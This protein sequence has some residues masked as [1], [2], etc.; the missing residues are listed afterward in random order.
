M[1]SLSKFLKEK[2]WT[3]VAVLLLLLLLLVIGGVPGYL[4]GRWQWKQPPPV[5][6][7][8]ELK[9]IRKAGLTLSGW[10]TVEQTEQSI[11]EH[12]WSL[13]I[14]KKADSQTQ[15]ILLLLPQNGP[16]D[17]PEVEW[18]EVNGWGK[19]R[20]GQWDIAQYRSAKLTIKYPAAGSNIETR[21]KARFFR[22]S[23][24]QETFA[25]LQ[26]YALPDGGDT[27]PI[28]WFLADQIAQW[29]KR[30]TPW[31]AVSILIPIE[32]LGQVET[33]WPLAQSLGETVQA[34]LMAGPLANTSQV[35]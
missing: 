29:H 7:L 16:M 18:T 4:T 31:V 13:Q 26:W 24:Q 28:H 30:R 15:A 1:I 21:V 5:V 27:S 32:P 3:Y 9:Q 23:T 10:Q 19:S 25:A 20:W 22:V 33:A 35:R 11:G 12:K 6:N 2:Q 14:L 17:Q 34:T 8:K